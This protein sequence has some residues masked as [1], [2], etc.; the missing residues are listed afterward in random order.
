MDFSNVGKSL[1][2][3]QMQGASEKIV[4]AYLVVR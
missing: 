1:K 2:L 4:E 3:L